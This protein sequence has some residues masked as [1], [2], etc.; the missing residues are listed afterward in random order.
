MRCV[1]HQA[2]QPAVAL[3]RIGA[4][5]DEHELTG[6]AARSEIAGLFRAR[7]KIVREQAGVGDEARVFG[8]GQR[9][10]PGVAIV[11]GEE[12]LV[13]TRKLLRSSVDG[14]A[15][16]SA[17]GRIGGPA[18][19][20]QAAPV[21]ALHSAVEHRLVRTNVDHHPA[22]C[23]L[24]AVRDVEHVSR[25][26]LAPDHIVRGAGARE[27]ADAGLVF[28]VPAVG[29]AESAEQR[30]HRERHRQV[31]QHDVI[32]GQRA[33]VNR[34]A[35][36]HRD[37]QLADHLARGI[38]HHVAQLVG[39]GRVISDRVI[40]AGGG[41]VVRVRGERAIESTAEVAVF[42]A[43]ERVIEANRIAP[44]LDQRHR[45]PG[46]AHDVGVD[47][48]AA[49][50]ARTRS[51]GRAALARDLVRADPAIAVFGLAI[52][53]ADRVDHPVA[54]E[55]VVAGGIG[56]V[57]VGSG[58]HIAAVE[59]GGDCAIDAQAS[60]GQLFLHRAVEAREK[61]VI[62]FG[63]HPA[64]VEPGDGFDALADRSHDRFLE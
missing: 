64:A 35:V 56:R 11:T 24:E 39:V 34:G 32:G 28:A 60:K 63:L 59:R 17:R 5:R 1:D 55:P 22:L 41:I 61:R 20:P 4:A 2:H 36:L 12:A 45:S 43:F 54:D 37:R 30:L 6:I 62:E 7:H 42:L 23:I 50:T 15:R 16:D 19:Q 14:F 53:Q 48:V 44:R 46:D 57:G 51:G 3:G 26:D 58:A 33:I 8:F 18:F 10:R 52:F 31:E 21:G 25:I 29:K 9:Q 47:G 38:D 27:Q 40:L 13:G 49:A